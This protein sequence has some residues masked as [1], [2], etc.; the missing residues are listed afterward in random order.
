MEPTKDVDSFS[1]DS[2][3]ERKRQYEKNKKEF[4]E[5]TKTFY[6]KQKEVKAK[7][8][9]NE[10]NIKKLN[11]KASKGQGAGFTIVFSF[12]ILICI[13]GM[14]YF[15]HKS[16]YQAQLNRAIDE[17]NQE[18]KSK[19]AEIIIKQNNILASKIQ[20][21]QNV[22][23]SIAVEKDNSDTVHKYIANL[24]RYSSVPLQ[25]K[26]TVD[27]QSYYINTDIIELSDYYISDSGIDTIFPGAIIKGDSLFQNNTYALVS[28]N[29]TPIYLTSNHSDGY[30]IEVDN[31]DYGTVSDALRIFQS[32][33]SDQ[34][35][36]E[37]TYNMRLIKS[38]EELNATLGINSKAGNNSLNIGIS[39]SQENTT[40]AVIFKQV[41]YTVVANPK[42]NSAAYFQEGTNLECLGYYEPAY[43]SSVDYGRMVTLLITSNMSEDKLSAEVGA[44][45]TGV[46][47]SAGVEKLEKMEDVNISYAFYGG[48]TDNVS[49]AVGNEGQEE[50]VFGR[51]STF[52]MG[53]DKETAVDRINAFID[54]S[55]GLVNPVPVSY[56]LKYLSDNSIIPTLSIYKQ[57]IF[58]AENAKLV[59]IELTEKPKE[60]FEV[61]FPTGTMRIGDNSFLW[62]ERIPILLEGTYDN[63]A[64]SVVVDAYA[65]GR[66]SYSIRKNFA[67]NTVLNLYISEVKEQ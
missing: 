20:E 42:Q 56:E 55:S 9:E 46:N 62:D 5:R 18:F 19:A 27:G 38:T 60:N 39:N 44:C 57:E 2:Y 40:I 14:S 45:F 24:E 1:K 34:N 36:K 35:A 7:Y 48:K 31:P 32:N 29:R 66:F 28:A 50:G 49:L 10:K 25:K 59:N 11:R 47:I 61:I 30:S 22:K 13:L 41:Y 26:A 67:Q 51:I 63:N 37:W 8:N 17:I 12:L 53:D 21:E 33:I 64:F 65:S 54:N 15:F 3:K 58:A 4:D 23:T 52:F 43:V 16:M 6:L